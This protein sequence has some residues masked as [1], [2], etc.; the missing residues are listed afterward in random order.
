MSLYIPIK[1]KSNDLSIIESIK[2]NGSPLPIN[3]G[4]W[5]VIEN[6]MESLHDMPNN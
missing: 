6:W 5:I 4:A 3:K 2:A 1:L